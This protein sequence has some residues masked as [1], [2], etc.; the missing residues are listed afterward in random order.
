[1]CFRFLDMT[2]SDGLDQDDSEGQPGHVRVLGIQPLT[3]EEFLALDDT[4]LTS[5]QVG[6]ALPQNFVVIVVKKK[7]KL[8]LSYI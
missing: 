3:L 2:M 5:L 6:V 8:N 7:N 1:M 4:T